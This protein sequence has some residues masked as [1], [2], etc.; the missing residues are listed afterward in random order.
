VHRR[1][2]LSRSLT[3]PAALVAVLLTVAGCGGSTKITPAPDA[4]AGACGSLLNRAPSTVLNG[5]RN[6]LD[7]A[8]AAS[9]GSP[10][11]VM[12]C[13]VTPPGP[14]ADHCIEVNDG[15]YWIYTQTKKTY[16]FVSYGR[17]PAV[18]VTVPTSVPQSNATDALIDLADAV[19]PL[20]VTG[21]CQ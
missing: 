3:G 17:V 10:A 21:H 6:S 18:E 12:R 4:S 16:D 13:G 11:V 19:R 15:L 2:Y 1:S 7:V 14:T 5:T 8:G 20:K 9:W